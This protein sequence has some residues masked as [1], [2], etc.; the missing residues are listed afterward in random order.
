[1]LT[2]QLKNNIM[3]LGGRMCDFDLEKFIFSAKHIM[4]KR[5]KNIDER[6]AP[7]EITGC[8]ATYLLL[9]YQSEYGLTITELAKESL[10]DKAMISRVIKELE[11]KNYVLK[12]NEKIRN[13]KI[14][15][16]SEGETVALFYK[17]T[18][19]EFTQNLFNKF[20][21]SE[22]DDLKRSANLLVERLKESEE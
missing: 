3:F 6:L 19:E 16:T 21:S 12:N 10:V 9:I 7:Y 13:F 5:M 1:M 2:N 4:K 18:I 14:Q 20:T 17:N 11:N 8:Y 22:L 15:L